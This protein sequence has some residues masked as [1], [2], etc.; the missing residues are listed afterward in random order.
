MMWIF[1]RT[2]G[3]LFGHTYVMYTIYIYVKSLRKF[4]C[5]PPGLMK[6]RN[7][8]AILNLGGDPMGYKL[9]IANDEP[10]I[11]AMPADFLLGRAMKSSPPQAARRH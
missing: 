8:S 5:R 3:L 6:N 7:L 10:D 2:D 9:L 11:V 4:F 1:G